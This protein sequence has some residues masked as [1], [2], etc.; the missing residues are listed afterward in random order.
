MIRSIFFPVLAG[1]I[2]ETGLAAACDLARE[3]DAHVVAVICISAVTPVPAAWSYYPVA[4]YETLSEAAKAT[5]SKLYAELGEKLSKAGVSY[6][7]RI[8][9]TLWMTTSEIAAVHARY[10]DITALTHSG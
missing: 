2:S 9:D 1:E 10:C 6:E 5:S 3:H 7:T 4:V 8:S